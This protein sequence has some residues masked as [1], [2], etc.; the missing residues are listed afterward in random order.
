MTQSTPQDTNQT[1]YSSIIVIAGPT[2]SGKSAYALD[3][4][5]ERDGVVI[6]ADSMQVYKDLPILTA[7]PSEEDLLEAPHRLYSV[8]DGAHRYNA[9]KWV[10]M[11]KA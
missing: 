9:Q 11:A 4:A 7:Q 10:E 8:L 5:K 6:N 2:A 1:L 3:L